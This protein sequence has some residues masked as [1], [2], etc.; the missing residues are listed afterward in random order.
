LGSFVFDYVEW[1]GRVIWLIGLGLHTIHLLV[2]LYRNVI[3]GVKRDTFVPS[4]FVTLAGIL[5]SVVVGVPMGMPGVLTVL[6]YYAF[7]MYIIAFPIM[8]YRIN[9]HPIPPQFAM[10]RVILLAPTSLVFVTYLN[11]A[12]TINQ[13]IVFALYGILFATIVYV[14]WKLPVFLGKPFNPAGHPALTFPTAIALVATF[15]MVGFLAGNGNDSL[16]EWLGHFFGIQLWVTTAIM[17]Y[18]GYNFVKIFT[19]SVKKQENC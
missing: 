1:F 11:V 14:S 15:R 17:A 9:K 2:F 12:N 16:A 18:V 13:A 7:G 4:W 6:M 8:I 10:T 5:V 3:K 19:N